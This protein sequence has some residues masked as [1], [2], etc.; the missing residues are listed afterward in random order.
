MDWLDEDEDD[1]YIEDYPE[2]R[3]TRGVPIANIISR[4]LCITGSVL[5]AVAAIICIMIG[6]LTAAM[7]VIGLMVILVSFAI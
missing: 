2:E 6:Q 4:V 5:A 1:E 3:E 7:V